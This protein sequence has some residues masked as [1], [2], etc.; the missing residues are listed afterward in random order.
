M[1]LL[2]AMN[3][4]LPVITYDSPTG[5]R[6][7]VT[8]NL[9]GIIVEYQNELRLVEKI[10]FLMQNDKFLNEMRENAINKSQS[11][12]VDK[13]MIQWEILFKQLRHQN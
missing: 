3:A 13:I 2:E 5:P 8:S 7:I 4:G 10:V 12:S 6:H 1:V 11:F 9:D